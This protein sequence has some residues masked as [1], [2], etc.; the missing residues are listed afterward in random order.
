MEHKARLCMC[1]ALQE[2]TSSS[3]PDDPL[4]Q[5]LLACEALSNPELKAQERKLTYLL[6]RSPGSLG[7]PGLQLQQ[8]RCLA[9]DGILFRQMDGNCPMLN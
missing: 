6:L 8:H 4:S 9:H 5:V 1:H 7:A 2:Y 3:G